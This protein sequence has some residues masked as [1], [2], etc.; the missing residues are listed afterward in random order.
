MSEQRG[1]SAFELSSDHTS[2]PK[3]QHTDSERR[4]SWRGRDSESSN[5]R[6]ISSTRRRSFE[7][8]PGHKQWWKFTLRS[9]DDDQE[10]DWWFA[11]TAIPLLAAT[12]GTLI[13]SSVYLHASWLELTTALDI[14][15]VE[16]RSDFHHAFVLY[17]RIKSR[18]PANTIPL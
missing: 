10:Q 14:T 15:Q 5:I 9:W 7:R 12:M 16:W 11:G 1:S 17:S 8:I 6:H 18:S 13:L 2:D 4:P 3:D